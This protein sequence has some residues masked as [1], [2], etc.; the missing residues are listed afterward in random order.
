MYHLSV[1]KH[2]EKNER[3]NYF[4]VSNAAKLVENASDTSHFAASVTVRERKV[5]SG[6]YKPCK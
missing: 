4:T 1:A 3:Q 2:S 6:V 5:L